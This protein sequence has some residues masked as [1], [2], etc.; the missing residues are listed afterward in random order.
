ME[1]TF[2]TIKQ[3]EVWSFTYLLPGKKLSLQDG[4]ISQKEIP[5]Y[6]E[7]IEQYKDRRV[8]KGLSQK[9]GLDFGNTYGPV[10][11]YGAI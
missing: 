7:D 2:E 11:K 4:S 10:L 5:L 1:D 8:T 6:S 3:N 9:P